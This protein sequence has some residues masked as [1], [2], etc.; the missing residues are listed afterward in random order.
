M[1]NQFISKEALRKCKRREMKIKDKKEV[2]LSKDWKRK[3][4]KV[5]K[6]TEEEHAKRIEYQREKS[7]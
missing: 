7:I 4:I 1:N 5:D 3:K 6:E 2:R